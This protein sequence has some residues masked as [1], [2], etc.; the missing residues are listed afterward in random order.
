MNAPIERLLPGHRSISPQLSGADALEGIARHVAAEG[1]QFTLS[2]DAPPVGQPMVFVLSSGTAV[3]GTI[4]WVLG[5][6]IGFAF[7]RPLGPDAIAELSSPAS[8]LKAIRLIAVA[9]AALSR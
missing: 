4:S 7:D 3:S 1:C 8:S 6:R 5:N 9:G 2:T